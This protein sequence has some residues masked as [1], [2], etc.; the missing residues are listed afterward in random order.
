MWIEGCPSFAA[1][2]A[3]QPVARSVAMARTPNPSPT[4]VGASRRERKEPGAHAGG[5]PV[6][7]ESAT[8]AA[9]RTVH[10]ASHG[11]SKTFACA[12]DRNTFGNTVSASLTRTRY[13][14]RAAKIEN[15]RLFTSASVRAHPA[16]VR[17]RERRSF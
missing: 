7:S 9:P 11:H 14:I 17:D 16:E 5:K 6:R 3:D 2:A 10:S 8:P 15:E 4:R 1:T 12:A 13:P